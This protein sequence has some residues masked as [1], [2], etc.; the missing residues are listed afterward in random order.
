MQG[1]SFPDWQPLYHQAVFE[2]NPEKLMF[3][4]AAARKAIHSRLAMLADHQANARERNALRN[5]LD[6]LDVVLEI[7]GKRDPINPGIKP[8]NIRP[9]A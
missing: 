2:L 8:P 4:V 3:R 6:V 5:A 1:L 7:E 9:A